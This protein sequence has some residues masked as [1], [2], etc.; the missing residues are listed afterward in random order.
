MGLRLLIMTHIIAM[1][2]GPESEMVNK[3]IHLELGSV[4]LSKHCRKQYFGVL[5]SKY[6]WLAVSHSGEDTSATVVYL[7]IDSACEV[8]FHIY[9]THDIS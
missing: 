2:N 9:P 3:L 8:S 6:C 1:I 7:L 5:G 4:L